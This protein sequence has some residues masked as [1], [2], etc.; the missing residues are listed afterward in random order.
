MRNPSAVD[1]ALAFLPAWWGG[2]RGKHRFHD[3][4]VFC[5]FLGY[6]KSG[7]SLVGALLDAHPDVAISHELHALKYAAAGFREHQI[8]HLILKRSSDFSRG[9]RERG[10]YV[11]DV[12]GQW[13]GRHRNLRVIGDKK[14]E[15]TTLWLPSQLD[16]LRRRIGAALRFIH[17]VRNP[18]DN[19]AR[20][21]LRREKT[22]EAAADHYFALCATVTALERRLGSGELF[23]IRHEVFVRDPRSS[24]VR[25]C[26]FLG[27]DPS[28][29]Y[30]EA[31]SRV[32]SPTPH[33]S[34]FDAP[35]SHRLIADVQARMRA[36]RYLEGY[37]WN[38]E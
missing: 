2:L 14:G 13:Q 8:Y 22:L 29:E 7:H 19:I 23:E 35:W 6:P 9:G 24:L 15:G 34:R 17:V 32:V 20:I 18:F 10:G 28:P 25:L 5:L 16:R 37:T 1:L 38:A 31:C 11:Y 30:L 12:A 4:R 27:I 21:A 26:G 3:V 33:R 36:I